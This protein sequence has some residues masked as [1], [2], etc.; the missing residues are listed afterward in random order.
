MTFTVLC[1][2]LLGSAVT[3][4]GLALVIRGLNDPVRPQPHPIPLTL[5]AGAAWPLVILG[6]AEMATVLLVAEAARR[7][8]SRRSVTKQANPM[9]NEQLNV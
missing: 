5:A 1:S 8:L 7:P 3:T 2:Y 4:I 9:F 6:A